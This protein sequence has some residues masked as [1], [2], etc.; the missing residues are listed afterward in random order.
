MAT[1]SGEEIMEIFN[2]QPGR[3]IGIIKEKIKEAI[4]DGE[5]P[6]EKEAARKLMIQLGKEEGL[7]VKDD[8][9]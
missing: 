6:N 5:I 3:V 4:L 8:N 9:I 2:I 7:V 1:V